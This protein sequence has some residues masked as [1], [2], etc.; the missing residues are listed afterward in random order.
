MEFLSGV[1]RPVAGTTLNRV[2]IPEVDYYQ[3]LDFSQESWSI[4][5]GK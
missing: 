3:L 1:E 5:E 4:T 2:R